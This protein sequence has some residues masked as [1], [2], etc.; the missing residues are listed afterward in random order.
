[1]A[2]AQTPAAKRPTA[3]DRAKAATRA[4]LLLTARAVFERD[5]YEAATIRSIAAAANVST[6]AIFNCWAA[7][8]AL[9]AEIFGYQA[10]ALRIA[11][12][13]LALA[14]RPWAESE[15]AERA[16]AT[17]AAT[18]LLITLGLQQDGEALADTASSAQAA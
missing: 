3:R 6:G 2:D 12:T 13:A 5:G 17:H 15:A 10:Q 4:K 16:V 7:K 11:E 14:G 8:D 9:F 1:M 18:L